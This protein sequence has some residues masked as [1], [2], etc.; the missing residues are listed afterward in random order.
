MAVPTHQIVIRVRYTEC[1]PMGVAHHSAY[2]PWFEM[3]RIELLRASGLTYNHLTEAHG[4]VLAVVELLIIY[5]RPIRYDDQLRLVTTLTEVG[6][7]RIRHE[8]ELWRDSVLA[9][10]GRTTL[11]CLGANGRVVELPVVLRRH[12]DGGMY[13]GD[14]ASSDRA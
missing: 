13:R 2:A 3:G 14:T 11:A 9:A 8:Y 7:V 5:R 10:T 6:H 12:A 4:I 1:D